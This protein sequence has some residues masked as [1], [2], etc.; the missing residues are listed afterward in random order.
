MGF[1]FPVSPARGD[2]IAV[3]APATGV[4]RKRF[5]P[6]LAWLCE[7]YR[8]RMLPS[9]FDENGYLAG[10]DA[11]RRDELASAMID[12]DVRAIFPARAG[13]GSMRIIDQLPWDEFEKD[14][15]WIVG[16][17]DITVLHVEATA[18]RI[19]SLHGPVVTTLSSMSAHARGGFRELL[20]GRERH[21]CFPHLEPIT[22]GTAE[23]V[24][25]GGNLSLLVVMAAGGRLNLP[26]GC[27]LAL[28]DTTEHPYRVDRMLTS[29]RLG[30][31]LARAAGIV[32][33]DWV[34]CQ[35]DGDGVTVME[36]LA[37][38]LSDLRVPVYAG[39][40]F[41][42]GAMNTPFVLG[43]DVVLGDGQLVAKVTRGE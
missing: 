17:S 40:T 38:C 28:E 22:P 7:H 30:G 39:A 34:N 31:H 8:I 1:T 23:G 18:R 33:G 41:G 32:L 11:R 13:Y 5:E 36:T 12:P 29:L 43:G 25:V 42:H 24:L 6:G 15:K 16:F 3:V 21:L 14:P 19:A 9:I 20:E 37:S 2:L 10:S 35:P 4:D 27:I 26:E